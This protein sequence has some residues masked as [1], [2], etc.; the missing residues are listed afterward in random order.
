MDIQYFLKKTHTTDAQTRP[1]IV[2]NDGFAFSAQ[3]SKHHYCYPKANQ[4]DY[5][6]IEIG[7]PSEREE[8]IIEYAEDTTRPTATIYGWVPNHIVNEMLEKRGG[9]NEEA[10]FKGYHYVDFLNKENNFAQDRKYFKT[11]AEAQEW[12]IKTFDSH[13]VNF[14]LIK[15][16]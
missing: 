4:T 11:S 12:M 7:N 15:S 1:E 14:E 10:T 3:A 16:F 2:C 6:S 5:D 13:K 8:T 9:I